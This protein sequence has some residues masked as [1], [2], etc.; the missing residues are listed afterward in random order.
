MTLKKKI[1]GPVHVDIRSDK[2]D[3]LKK[4]P[5]IFFPNYFKSKHLSWWMKWHKIWLRCRPFEPDGPSSAWGVLQESILF[6]VPTN[7]ETVLPGLGCRDMLWKIVKLGKHMNTK[8]A[9]Y[10]K[11]CTMTNLSIFFLASG[12]YLSTVVG[13]KG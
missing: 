12:L 1:P 6:V 7:F 4:G 8:I 10:F 2:L 9:R 11:A 13:F 3:Y 5:A